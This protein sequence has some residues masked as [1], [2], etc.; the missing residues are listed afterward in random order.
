MLLDESVRVGN[1]ELRYAFR[2]KRCHLLAEVLVRR[3]TEG[4]ADF[5]AEA[6]RKG[7]DDF[8]DLPVVL[9][10]RGFAERQLEMLR[11]LADDAF[12]VLLERVEELLLRS[13]FLELL[14][15]LLV[16][17]AVEL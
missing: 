1:G 3:F 10:S 11:H 13:D 8:G 6:L 15:R 2:V 14:R 16:E 17:G 9:R 12:R 5:R 4:L 7:V